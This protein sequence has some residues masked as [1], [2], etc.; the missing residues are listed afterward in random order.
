MPSL[1]TDAV[2]VQPCSYPP[3]GLQLFL[4]EV[5]TTAQERAHYR[6]VSVI[7]TYWLPSS[8]TSQHF[9]CHRHLHRNVL[10]AIVIYIATFW[11][12]ESLDYSGRDIQV[13]T[14]ERAIQVQSKTSPTSQ[15]SADFVPFGTGLPL[16][17]S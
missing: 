15:L 16:W 7:A 17:R 12:P 6:T 1:S 5:Q 8:S 11:L 13:H 14:Q 4:G 3:R 9:G 2:P 10:I